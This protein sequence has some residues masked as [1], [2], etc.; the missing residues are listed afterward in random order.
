M[1]RHMEQDDIILL[2]VSPDFLASDYCY[3]REMQRALA[4][5]E[6]GTAVVIPVILRPCDW[7]H[8]PF[9]KL[10][11]TPTDGRPINQWADRD[12]AMLEVARAVR[13][14]AAQLGS[15]ESANAPK[16]AASVS[17]APVAN[18]RPPLKQL[19]RGQTVLGPRPRRLP[20]RNLRLHCPLF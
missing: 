1:D 6:T 18:R 14:A 19:A 12:Q 8:A 5:H 7:H 16:P 3:E 2:L 13:A 15:K 10:L 11:A 9:G 20:C 17:V 4:R